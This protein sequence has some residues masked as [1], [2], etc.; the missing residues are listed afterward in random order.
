MV[1]YNMDFWINKPVDMSRANGTL[2]HDVPNRGNVRSLELNV[3]G[4]A[5]R[6]AV[7]RL[8]RRQGGTVPDHRRGRCLSTG[9]PIRLPT[10]RYPARRRI[11]NSI[12]R[13]YIPTA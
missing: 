8:L 10:A 2:L 12:R 3:G 11:T 5:G 6:K 9:L 4:A 1:E 7:T 13:A